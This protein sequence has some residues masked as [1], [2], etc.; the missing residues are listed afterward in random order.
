MDIYNLLINYTSHLYFI[1][2]DSSIIS[3]LLSENNMSIL[4]FDSISFVKNVV[5][6]SKYGKREYKELKN[7]SS[8]LKVTEALYLPS[9]YAKLVRASLLA[10]S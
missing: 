1:C 2:F 9:D 4:S 8:S 6:I 10:K 7:I 3:L 5:S